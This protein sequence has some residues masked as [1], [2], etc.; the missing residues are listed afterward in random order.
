[1]NLEKQAYLLT[2][3][4]SLAA[5]GVRPTKS[6]IQ[7]SIFLLSL[8]TGNYVPFKFFWNGVPHSYKIEEELAQMLSYAAIA[9][10]PD[11]YPARSMA[12]HPDQ[13]NAPWL[14]S[15][16]RLEPQAVQRIRT[17]CAFVACRGKVP[18]DLHRQATAAWIM[19][20]EHSTDYYET[21][22][23]FRQL[24]YG[25]SFSEISDAV[26]TAELWFRIAEPQQS[27]ISSESY[28]SL[29]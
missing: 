12:F 19:R 18:V 4:E 7:L 17:L 10:R 5:A 16:H 25:D 26:T 20:R 23:R 2:M 11:E 21:I 29:S 6:H 3:I 8:V 24:R 28:V 22:R 15:R 13:R 14:R 27:P 1:M 9:Y